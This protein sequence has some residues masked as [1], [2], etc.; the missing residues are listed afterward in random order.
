[1]GYKP[2]S[3]EHRGYDYSNM[4]SQRELDR[5]SLLKGGVLWIAVNPLLVT[6]HP[7]QAQAMMGWS[8]SIP[9]QTG[10]DKNCERMIP[11]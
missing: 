10:N 11:H 6:M 4:L 7:F 9:T 2:S 3:Q 8:Q 5:N 1:M